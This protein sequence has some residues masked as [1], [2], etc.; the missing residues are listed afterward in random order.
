VSSSRFYLESIA[1]FLYAGN[2][3]KEALEIRLAAV[4]D[5]DRDS[6]FNVEAARRMRLKKRV[7]SQDIYQQLMDARIELKRN[8]L[9]TAERI[10]QHVKQE[11]EA[12][13]RP[14]T[15]LNQLRDEWAKVWRMVLTQQKFLKSAVVLTQAHEELPAKAAAEPTLHEVKDYIQAINPIIQRELHHYRNHE[16]TGTYPY[17]CQ[18]SA[19]I[20][21][22]LLD[23]KFQGRLVSDVWYG[24]KKSIGQMHSWII[25]RLGN[26]KYFLSFAEGQYKFVSHKELDDLR[27]DDFN[28]FVAAYHERGFDSVDFREI[29]DFAAFYNDEGLANIK[30]LG[31]PDSYIHR[32]VLEPIILKINKETSSAIPKVPRRLGR[33]A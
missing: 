8:K 16:V 25:L 22:R 19:L 5:E 11:I 18:T 12:R 26:K 7:W 28:R 33:A 30:Y 6:T 20:G 23:S 4:P 21:K 31:N 24:M 3:L 14:S 13:T 32:L 15:A 17:I 1:H 2:P 9:E 10:L 29:D 27:T